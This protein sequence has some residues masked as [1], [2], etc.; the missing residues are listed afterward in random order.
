MEFFEEITRHK[1][2]HGILPVELIY[3]AEEL[4]TLMA[5]YLAFC[6]VN[7]PQEVVLIGDNLEGQ[8][9]LPVA[10]LKARYS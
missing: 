2:L 7:C 3:A 10:D 1:L 6:V 9:A 8:I 4:D 5:A